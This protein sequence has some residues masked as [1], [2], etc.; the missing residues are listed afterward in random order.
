MI[1][2]LVKR[3]FAVR[4]AN[5]IAEALTSAAAPAARVSRQ[6]STLWDNALSFLAGT[7]K[8][9]R[10]RKR[11]GLVAA[12]HSHFSQRIPETELQRLVDQMIARTPSAK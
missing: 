8:N 5:S 10:P 1:K 2:H 6:P 9:R 11:K 4:R 12:L 3:G 7:Q